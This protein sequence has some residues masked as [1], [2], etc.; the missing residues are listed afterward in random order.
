MTH[1]H[2]DTIYISTRST[3]FI[4]HP[5]PQNK[6]RKMFAQRDGFTA[7]LR[8]C[9]VHFK[10]SFKSSLV[11]RKRAIKSQVTSIVLQSQRQVCE[12]IL[13]GVIADRCPLRWITY[14]QDPYGHQLEF[15]SS[16]PL[17]QLFK[18]AFHF[19][20]SCCVAFWRRHCIVL[21]SFIFSCG[22]AFPV[23]NTRGSPPTALQEESDIISCLL[24]DLNK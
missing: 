17:S 1:S 14:T 2:V 19:I 7:H 10:E 6:K 22:A 5:N 20:S 23:V 4:F 3:L 15:W 21:Y 13:T 9:L 11:W 18:L 8:A 16:G 24:E 12:I